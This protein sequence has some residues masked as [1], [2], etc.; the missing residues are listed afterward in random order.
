MK[1]QCVLDA[2]LGFGAGLV[3]LAAWTAIWVIKLLAGSPAM[4]LAAF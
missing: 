3:V 2:L 1:K 4:A